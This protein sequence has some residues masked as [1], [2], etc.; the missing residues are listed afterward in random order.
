MN[1]G[2][3]KV[4]IGKET[5]EID[6]AKETLI[7]D[8]SADM[9]RV[10]SQI[11]W[12]GE[13]LGAAEAERVRVDSG[14]RRWRAKIAKEM[15]KKD[16]KISEWKVKAEIESSNTFAEFKE[17]IAQA[18]HQYTALKELVAALKEKSPN[19]RSKGAR[20]RAELDSTDM[21]TRAAQNKDN[22]RRQHDQSAEETRS[23]KQPRKPR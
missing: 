14:Y 17:A 11:A 21:S 20:Q 5:I 12:F 10:A 9:D 19:L 22:L 7:G 18:E 1:K 16:P 15:L 2:I 3:I 6:T 4:A 23:R 8:V 13:L